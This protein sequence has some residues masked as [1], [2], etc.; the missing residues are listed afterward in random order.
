MPD[1][2]GE[3]K[4]EDEESGSKIL[5]SPADDQEPEGTVGTA[6]RGANA[7]APMN[8]KL[9]GAGPF[10]PAG[11]SQFDFNTLAGD[12][13]DNSDG[14]EKETDEARKESE[15]EGWSSERAGATRPGSQTAAV[16]FFPS[17]RH[18]K[19]IGAGPFDPE[20]SPLDDN[21]ISERTGLDGSAEV[22]N[23]QGDEERDASLDAESVSPPQDLPHVQGHDPAWFVDP[24]VNQKLV[25]PATFYPDGSPTSEEKRRGLQ[26]D[27]DDNEDDEVEVGG[28]VGDIS[29]PEE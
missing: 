21:N 3:G 22:G 29:N 26:N 16:N 9:V 6:N 10:D 2:V 11:V 23:G 28:A 25:G 12:E 20:R 17:V 19:L 24:D 5:S 27:A 18:C 7:G 1:D 15:C 13:G 4:T 8:Y 14:T